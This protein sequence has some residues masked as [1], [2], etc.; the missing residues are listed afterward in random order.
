[1][2]KLPDDFPGLAALNKAGVNTYSQLSKFSDD[3][4][5]IPGI[6]PVAASNIA[7]YLA[8]EKAAEPIVEGNAIIEKASDDE[9]IDLSTLPPALPGPPTRVDGTPCRFQYD[10][11][12]I[13]DGLAFDIDPATNVAGEI[14]IGDHKYHGVRHSDKLGLINT[15]G[16]Y[17]LLDPAES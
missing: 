15:V 12:H 4:T 3:Y 5:Q 13:A 17:T 14:L 7:D 1:M 16:A 9:P 10:R 2:P 6:G 11:D 8:A